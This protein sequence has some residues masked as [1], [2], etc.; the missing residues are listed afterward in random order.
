MIRFL[1]GLLVIT[2]LAPRLL[3]GQSNYQPGLIVNSKGDTVRGYINYAEW[4][5]NPQSIW[6]KAGDAGAAEKLS[7]SEVKYFKVFVGHLAAYRSYIGP[8]STDNTEINHLSVGRDTSF[9][10]DTVFLRVIQEG[11]N[12]ILFSHEDSQ[13]IRFFIAGNFSERPVELIYRIYYKDKDENGFDRT[14][15]ENDYKGQLYDV[16]AKHSA[17]NPALKKYIQQCDY[18]MDDLLYIASKINGLSESDVAKNNPIKPKGF[19]KVFA[20]AGA[21]LVVVF[22]IT[23][24]ANIHS[25]PH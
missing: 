4:G 16:A 15:Y 17:M 18:K 13:K 20:V 2:L 3:F 8:V 21:I 6:F 10:I 22:L 25:S 7:P 9:R 24:I 12:L 11:K 1:P 5:N 23:E 14:S 19:N